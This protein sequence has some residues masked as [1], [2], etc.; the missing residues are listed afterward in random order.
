MPT[1]LISTVWEDT[2]GARI[3]VPLY[4]DAADITTLALAQTALTA[5]EPL[6]HAVSGNAI[7]EAKVSFNLNVA[8]T[9]TPDAGYRVDAGAT[10]GF[11]DS[12]QV[13][14]S[15]YLPGIL[16]DKIVN[17]IVAADDTDVLALINY[18]TGGTY[19]LS[20]RGSASLWANYRIGRATVRKIRR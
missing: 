6:L 19:P 18:I 20:S 1:V 4:F 10:L 2:E 12:D 5:Y 8:G 9:E 3:S 13:G 14:Q 15:L 7:V 16:E 17:G 11:T